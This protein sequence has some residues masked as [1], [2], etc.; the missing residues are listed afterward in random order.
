MGVS[1]RAATSSPAKESAPKMDSIKHNTPLKHFI[2]PQGISDDARF[3]LLPHPRD[4]TPKRFLFCPQKGIF[5]FTQLSAPSTDPRSLLF[6]AAEVP[7]EQENLVEVSGDEEH[8]AISGGY[9][10]REAEVLVA[11]PFDMAFLLLPMIPSAKAGPGKA[12]FQPV[13]D[14]LEAHSSRNK[15]WKYIIDI[16]RPLVEEAMSRFCDTVEAGDERMYL[17]SEDKL[18]QMILQKADAVVANGLPTSLE[19]KFVSRVL[20]TPFRSIKRDD[21]T[22]SPTID[23]TTSDETTSD[24]TGTLAGSFASQSTAASSA[25]SSVFSQGSATSSTASTAVPDAVPVDVRQLQRLR[26]IVNFM[27]FSYVPKDVAPRLQERLCSRHSPVN[28][29]P[30]EEYL[31]HIA[32][33]RAEAVAS[34]SMSDYNKKRSAEDIEAAE[35]RAEKKRKQEEEEKK[36]KAGESRGVRELRKVDVSGMKK[37]SDF[38]AKKPV[39]RAK[40]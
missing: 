23:E 24:E 31:K 6:S 20:E 2:L 11:A 7:V 19:D 39:A 14:L 3:L 27:L 8:K 40:G 22:I 36:R 5:E 4:A 32:T 13:D 16:G 34:M 15:H 9:L 37:M 28:F 21:T 26:T 12:L 30:L 18:V 29:E 1:T 35:M 25:S 17:P 38:F 33:L 10:S